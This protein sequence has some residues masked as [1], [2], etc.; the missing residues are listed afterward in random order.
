MAKI[1]LEGILKLVDVQIDPA[2]FQKISRLTAG[3][4]ANINMTVKSTQNLNQKMQQVQKTVQGTANAMSGMDRLGHQFLQRMTQFAILL[5][6]FATLNKAIQG[7]VKFMADFEEELINVIK[8]NPTELT[9]RLRE[10]IDTTFDI[11]TSMGST[12]D[13]VIKTTK[14]FVQAGLNI[15]DA[16]EMSRAATLA[17]KV[18]TLDLTQAQ[19]MLLAVSKQFSAEGLNAVSIIDKISR[20]EDISASNAQDFAE[21]LKTGGNAMAF[22]TKSFDKTIALIAAL[23]EQ[24]RKSGSELGTFFKTMATRMTAGGESTKA[25]E[26]LGVAV[27][28]TAGKLRP[29]DDILIDLKTKFDTLTEAQK[30]SLA[31]QIAGVRQVEG[32]LAAL[33]AL[34]REQEILTASSN[35]SGTANRKLVLVMG[36]L[37]SQTNVMVSQFQHLAEAIGETGI[38]DIFKQAVTFAGR[39]AEGLVKVSQVAKE[40]GVSLGPLLALGALKIGG[41]A[42]GIAALGGGTQP[43]TIGGLA[44]KSSQTGQAQALKGFNTSIIMATTATLGL[45]AGQQLLNTAV[46]QLT[47]HGKKQLSAEEQAVIDITNMGANAAMAAAQFSILSPGIGATAGALTLL[48][49]GTNLVTK[50]WSRIFGTEGIDEAQKSFENLFRGIKEEGSHLGQNITDILSEQIKAGGGQISDKVKQAMETKVADF[51]KMMT[52]SGQG[53]FKGFKSETTLDPMMIRRLAMSGGPQFGETQKLLA[54]KADASSVMNQFFVDLGADARQFSEEAQ[55]QI[56][57]ADEFLKG[58]DIFSIL[59]KGEEDLISIRKQLQTTQGSNIKLFESEVEI[60]KRELEA[61]QNMLNFTQIQID[62]LN[63]RVTAAPEMLGITGP[64]TGASEVAKSFI[65]DFET[66]LKEVGPNVQGILTNIFSGKELTD[67]QKAY[68]KLRIDLEKELANKEL[69]MAEKSSNV[70]KAGLKEENDMMLA[71]KKAADIVSDSFKDI[72][73]ALIDLGMGSKGSVDDLKQLAKLT[74]DDFKDIL[75][76]AD[77]FSEGVRNAVKL[78]FGTDVQKAE[79]NFANVAAKSRFE[80][81][82]LAQKLQDINDELSKT[83]EG[84]RSS[85][86]GK[87]RPQL[88]EEQAT[89][90]AALD[91]ARMQSATDLIK[92]NFQ[93]GESFKSLE[94]KIKDLVSKETDAEQELANARR[95]V[96]DATAQVSQSFKD[97]R[98]SILDF[99]GQM[100][101][102]KINANLLT[103][104]IK[105]LGGGLNTVQARITALNAAYNDVLS[106][107][108][109]TLQQ[110][111]GLEKQLAETTLSFLQQAQT[112]ITQAGLGVYGQTAQQNRDLAVG[113]QGLSVVAEKL[114]GS[115]DHFLALGQDQFK[116]I[117]QELLNLP[118]TL[119]EK[120]LSALEQLPSTAMIGGFSAEQLKTALGSVGAGVAPSAG[121]PSLPDLIKKQAEQMQKLQELGIK[122]AQLQI[123]QVI[124]SQ[125]ALDTAKSQLDEAKIQEDRAKEN[126]ILIRDQIGM[127][128]AIL[129][130]AYD[131]REK[132]TQRVIDATNEAEINQITASNQNAA[133]QISAL[134]GIQN[135]LINAMSASSATATDTGNYAKGYV[136][137]FEFGNLNPKEI[138]GL[139]QSASDEKSAMPGGAKLAIANTSEAIIPTNNR[140]FIPHFQAGNIQ[141]RSGLI[142]STIN[143][144]RTMNPTIV[145]AVSRSVIQG[146]QRIETGG[147]S[148]G[149]ANRVLGDKLDKM[150]NTLSE[151]LLSNN[152]LNTKLTNP[153]TAGT[154]I[155]GITSAAKLEDININV[156]TNQQNTVTVQ[157]LNKLEEE[158]RRGIQNAAEQHS[159]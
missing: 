121:L 59:I 12:A 120:M 20:A 140:G 144:I 50:Y 112:S 57:K 130:E 45:A 32:F 100:A 42:F 77:N 76:E 23:R 41:K 98:Q 88:I 147:K 89:A 71:N 152:N 125:K 72:N 5:P 124:N 97:F 159:P 113:I 157:G 111:I 132:L 148:P 114:G 49:E 154:N 11:A 47:E 149:E 110:R 75:S 2:I 4:P 102:A 24:T 128:I 14:V 51:L 96:I 1:Q 87:S 137:R 105:S 28:D 103:I 6:I 58:K 31:A 7:S 135:T 38:L 119:R 101:S 26:S 93:I 69:D 39:I 17:S 116:Q 60:R 127:E 134:Q 55:S 79:L 91:K 43:S 33:K 18:T 16:M 108:N 34:D 62:E 48:V 19:E 56:E 115:F 8:T 151:I 35:A 129:Q 153:T 63:K 80:I 139:L 158:L 40:V 83:P 145:A 109:M 66:A 133:S 117:S 3:M 118:V 90:E 46:D 99:N 156:T 30:S 123:T 155:P 15:T 68:I 61:S 136:P 52:E 142:A 150:S 9:G 84:T 143:S 36:E 85:T 29:M 22:A 131:Q 65:K 107:T 13:E 25:I 104:D 53:A 122:D 21:A 86:T 67:N 54:A 10:I 74:P 44:L 27:S 95:N 73:Q 70:R 81:E 138:M 64:T 141:E 106:K 78:A 94:D 92:A 37:K 146:L 126:A 82:N